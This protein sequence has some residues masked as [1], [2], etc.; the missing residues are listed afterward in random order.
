MAITITAGE[1]AAGTTAPAPT[2]PATPQAGDVH[3]LFIGSKPFSTTINT[4]TGWTLIT[5]TNGTNGS[6]AG[7]ID[8]GSVNC[9]SFYRVWQ[10]GDADPTIS[11]TTG[12]TALAVIHRFRPTAG[13]T[14]DTPVGDKGSDSTSDT[15]FSTTMGSDI[16]ITANDA[17]VGYSYIAGD[18]ATFSTATLTATG[19]T[20]GTVTESPATEGVTALGADCAASAMT[21]L[22]SAGPSS[23]AAV[24]GWTL[25]VAQTGQSN[26]I[27]IRETVSSSIVGPLIMGKLT[28]SRLVNGGLAR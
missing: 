7:G 26:L 18:N 11:I 20:V 15:T 2:M 12:N 4:P 21:A 27:R 22:P 1:W 3:V 13:S 24:M 28:N 14:I 10:S 9:A 17:L 6:V 19:V 16:G 23:A 5:N 8:V 25:S